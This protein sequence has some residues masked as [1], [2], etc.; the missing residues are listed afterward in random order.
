MHPA[1]ADAAIHAGAALRAE[2]EKDILVSSSVGHYDAQNALQGKCRRSSASA[3]PCH[4]ALGHCNYKEG[5]PHGVSS[6]KL[7]MM[8]AYA[9]RSHQPC[10]PGGAAAE[11]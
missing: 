5:S 9:H 11:K 4:D 1:G 6:S 10:Q 3:S 7:K 8:R 2:E